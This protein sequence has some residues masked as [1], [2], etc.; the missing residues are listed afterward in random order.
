MGWG[1][2]CEERPDHLHAVG[3][4]CHVSTSGYG[5]LIVDTRPLYGVSCG[6]ADHY[7]DVLCQLEESGISGTVG[8]PQQRGLDERTVG[9]VADLHPAL[10][11]YGDLVIA[12]EAARHAVYQVDCGVRAKVVSGNGEP[13]SI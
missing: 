12:V 10:V 4:P 8:Q 11:E 2:P 13:P 6:I 7:R 1:V 9:G 3:G 5:V